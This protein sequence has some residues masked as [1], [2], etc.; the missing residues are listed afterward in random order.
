MIS[1]WI[2]IW[3]F[4]SP[5]LSST[6]GLRALGGYERLLSRNSPGTSLLSLSHGAAYILNAAVDE[7]VL[8]DAVSRCMRR[9]PMLRTFISSE[10]DG[11]V[12]SGDRT[13]SGVEFQFCAESDL[14]ELAKGVVHT[15]QVHSDDFESKWRSELERSLNCAQL[16]D[17]GPLWRLVNI[18]CNDDNRKVSWVFCFNHGIDDQKSVNILVRDLIKCCRTRLIKGGDLDSAFPNKPLPFP[19]SVESAVAPQFPS[20]STVTWALY[21]LCNA[22]R[23]PAMIPR[24]VSQL[25]KDSPELRQSFRTPELRSTFIEPFILSQEVSNSLRQRCKARGVTV[26]SI[27]SA[28]MLA[29]TS[30][31]IDPSRENILLR[32]LLSVD[33]RPFGANGQDDWAQGTVACAAG[34]VDYLVDVSTASS[35]RVVGE[36]V[37]KYQSLDTELQLQERIWDLASLCKERADNIIQKQRRVE[38]SVRLFGLGMQFA[39]V[40]KVVELDAAS[41]SLGRGFSCGVSNMGLVTFDSDERDSVTSG[42]QVNSAFYATSHSRNG[43]LCQLSCLTVPSE[44]GGL[45]G[46]LQ[47]TRPLITSEEGMRF[48]YDLQ[49]L[50]TKLSGA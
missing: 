17:T 15:V 16:P 29:L 20:M 30:T 38:E 27:L 1:I 13:A 32:F 24:R 35:P 11:G 45:C 44:E 26:T 6:V 49:Q 18:V 37:A 33:L 2:W 39:D 47:F 9:H 7:N 34:A 21:Q 50:L 23:M 3:I 5:G 4:L 31:T 40:L 14:I 42:L 36:S 12:E 10:R 43:V 8:I 41:G 48:S 22:L 19:A 46:C 28:A 25:C